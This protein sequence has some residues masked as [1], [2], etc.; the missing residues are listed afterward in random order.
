MGTVAIPRTAKQV[1]KELHLPVDSL[2]QRSIQAFLLQ[3]MRAAQMDIA[4][5]IDNLKRL[6]GEA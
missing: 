3:E 5:F 1:A 4:D 6:L 2:I